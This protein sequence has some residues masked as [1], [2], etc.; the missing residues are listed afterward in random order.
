MNTDLVVISIWSVSIIIA[1]LS[2]II[3]INGAG[4]S[5]KIFSTAIFIVSIWIACVGLLINTDNSLYAI[6]IIRLNYY[7]GNL[8]ASVFCL[9][10]L[11]FPSKNSISEK[12]IYFFVVLQLTFFYIY[13]FTNYIISDIGKSESISRWVWSFGNGSALFDIIFFGFFI[14]GVHRL[15]KEYFRT[16]GKLARKNIVSMLITIIL[17]SIP[18]TILCILLP[19]FNVYDFNWLGAILE[20]IWVPIIMYSIIKHRQ[21]NVTNIMSVTIAILL[22]IAFIFNFFIDF[23]RLYYI[24]IITLIVF[25][26][27]MY[28]L[29]T[30]IKEEY[31]ESETLKKINAGLSK[32]I[33][34]QTTE[35]RKAYAIE[36]K[37][38]KDLEKL[39]ETK[40]QFILMTQHNLRTPI[41]TIKY[42]LESLIAGESG[43]IDD[44]A[45]NSVIRTKDS[46]SRLSQIVD[47]FLNITTLKIDSQILKLATGNVRSIIDNIVQE[48]RLDI[49]AMRLK[50]NYIKS[51][52]VWPEIKMDIGK[53]REALSIIIEN[54]VKYNFHRGVINI[55]NKVIDN[56][57]VLEIESTGV[58][59]TPEERSNLFNKLFY[60]SKRAQEKNPIGM[61]IGLQVAKA[62]ISGHKGRIDIDSYGENYGA[63]VEIILPINPYY[64][65]L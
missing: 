4:L 14:F 63:K 39:N 9:L 11:T 61:G 49:D 57:L 7:L 22:A 43:Y 24:K 34:F 15:I 18:A 2:L 31:S 36:N 29:I 35:I 46:T 6:Y 38:R 37:A 20:I 62:I 33:E 59:I 13:I 19:R 65:A 17:G 48:L 64:E 16:Q 40:D 27:L 52:N 10:F 42:E 21:M 12:I 54:A 53:I 58:G 5:A 55:S 8:I 47:D 41:T 50:V 23:T 25:I 1:A 45:R 3:K 28:Y 30:K 26:F 44:R 60:R 56:N 32:M 51:S